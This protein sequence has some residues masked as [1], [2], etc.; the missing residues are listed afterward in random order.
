MIKDAILVLVT[1]SSVKEADKIS[2]ILLDKKLIA[3]ANILPGVIS[4]FRWKGDIEKAVEVLIM[5]KTR[6]SKFASI[7]NEVRR[8]HSYEVPEVIAI[9]IKS[10]SKCYLEWIQNSVR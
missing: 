1:C 10:G 4:K 9:P 7:D 6:A 3:C 8:A 2:G 5:A